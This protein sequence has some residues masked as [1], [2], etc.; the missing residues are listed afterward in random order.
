MHTFRNSAD[1]A[2]PSH[3]RAKLTINHKNVRR[4][5]LGN[6]RWWKKEENIIYVAIH[7]GLVGRWV[8]GGRTNAAETQDLKHGEWT[9]SREQPHGSNRVDRLLQGTRGEMRGRSE[10]TQNKW[11]E[12]SFWNSKTAEYPMP[13]FLSHTNRTKVT[14]LCNN[15]CTPTLKQ[16]E[17]RGRQRDST[18]PG[19]WLGRDVSVLS[20]YLF[21][22][23]Q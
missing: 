21:V 9:G 1:E 15:S 19:R 20:K 14:G 13:F 16:T 12:L 23:G 17:E 11:D 8:S 6:S 3:P 5:G 7:T 10:P 22:V 18:G 2:R 4:S